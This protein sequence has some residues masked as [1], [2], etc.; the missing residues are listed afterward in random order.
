[1]TEAGVENKEEQ[2]GG[3]GSGGAI[4]LTIFIDLVGFSIIFPILPAMLQWYLPREGAD[5]LVG[6][7]EAWLAAVTPASGGGKV[8][9]LVLFGGAL[10]SLFS[11]LQ[12]ISSPVWGR[13]SDRFGR[14]NILLITTS[15]TCLAYLLWA[16]SGSFWVYVVSRVLCGLMA[17]NISVATAAMADVTSTGSRTRGMAFVGVAFALG[18]MIGPAI[19]GVASLIDLTKLWPG[20]VAYGLNPFSGAAFIS[21]ALSLTNYF[22]VKWKFPETL[23]PEH[24]MRHT[25]SFNPFSNLRVDNPSIVKVILVDFSFLMVF[26]GM[27]F[28]LTFLALERLGFGPRQ[29]IWIFIFVGVVMTTVQGLFTQRKGFITKYGHPRLI[30]CGIVLGLTGM[31][32]LALSNTWPVFFLGLFLKACGIALQAPTITALVSLYSPANKQGSVMGAFRAMGSLARAIGPMIAAV[33]YWAMGSRLTY[34]VA[35]VALAVPLYFAWKLPK[36]ESDCK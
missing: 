19:G 15:C 26:S 1:M 20:G 10:G 29:N 13:L 24:R 8:L 12:F 16:F 30:R 3:R 4:F 25:I 14:R 18:F 31:V 27:E 17:G 7:F 23:R 34:L 11:V 32:T 9:T 35:S 21:V 2:A 5:S 6:H 28:T 33:L 36:P 22:W